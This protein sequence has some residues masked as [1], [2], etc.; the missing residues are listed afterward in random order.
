[1]GLAIFASAVAS[2]PAAITGLKAAAL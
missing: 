1:M 2:A